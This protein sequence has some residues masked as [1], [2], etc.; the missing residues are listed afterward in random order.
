[1]AAQHSHRAPAARAT[2]GEVDEARVSALWQE[3]AG[4]WHQERDGEVIAALSCAPLDVRRFPP[5]RE[6]SEAHRGAG[7]QRSRLCA[8]TRICPVS[9]A[10]RKRLPDYRGIAAG[11]AGG[12]AEMG[13][14]PVS[15]HRAH[16]GRQRP[17][18][19]VRSG[20]ATAA[21]RRVRDTRGG[22]AARSRFESWPIWK[23]GRF[24]ARMARAGPDSRQY[25]H[26]PWWR[27]RHRQSLRPP[28]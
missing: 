24:P 15:A 16:A 19:F 14:L 21:P 2:A 18:C 5:V 1:M 25:C 12:S 27:R 6:A 26:H 9:A 28:G 4:S 17:G 13:L 3:R 8:R 20:A 22:F 23:A 10:T 11:H 7:P